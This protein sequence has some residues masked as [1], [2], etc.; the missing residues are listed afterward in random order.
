M[1]T[2]RS[3]I[4]VTGACGQIG[5]ELV[6]ALRARHGWQNV[7]AS[8]IHPATDVM[9]R[10]GTY[11]RLDV[12]DKRRLSNAVIHL[13]IGEIYHLAAVLSAKGEQNPIGAWDLN[14][15]GLLNVLEVAREK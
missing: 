15:Q 8:D 6:A 10:G 12:T 4:L 14:M 1:M 2:T 3:K 5:T 11:V 9:Q 7:I 13:G